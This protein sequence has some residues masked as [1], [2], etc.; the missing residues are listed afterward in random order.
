MNR[1][2]ERICIAAAVLLTVVGEGCGGGGGTTGPGGSGYYTA[3]VAGGDWNDQVI[4]SQGEDRTYFWGEAD[5]SV[6][7]DGVDPGERLTLNVEFTDALEALRDV[8]S[9]LEVRLIGDTLGGAFQIAVLT[10]DNFTEQGDW[11]LQ[12]NAAA[13]ATEIS[14]G[15][16]GSIDDFRFLAWAQ[17]SAGTKSSGFLFNFVVPD[18]IDGVAIPPGQML[19]LYRIRWQTY[20][21]GDQTAEPFPIAPAK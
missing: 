16:T 21:S 11:G 10:I 9:G 19:P 14:G 2:S 13:V 12:V 5:V 1:L 8:D 4:Y 18:E 17:P 3:S 20:Y 15:N 7:I 6:T